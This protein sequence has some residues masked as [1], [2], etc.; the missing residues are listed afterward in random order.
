MDI[1][2]K[3]ILLLGGAGEVGMAIARTLL[4]HEEKPGKLVV[5]SLKKEEAEAA[6][7]ELQQEFPGVGVEFATEYGNIF[8]REEF[9]DRA[10]WELQADPACQEALMDD[11][12]NEL[13]PEILQNST[14]YQMIL[15][16]KPHLIV[17]TIN[18]ATALAY[19]DVYTTARE[20]RSLLKSGKDEE[21]LRAVVRRL[22]STLYIP[23]LVRHVQILHRAMEEVGV[24][25]YLK[26]GTTG[27][28][29]MGLNIPYT[30]GEERPSRVLLSKSAVAGAHSLLLFLADRTPRGPIVKEIKPAALIAWKAIGSGRIRKR[31][32]EFPLYQV[33]LDQAVP[34]KPGE[35]FD[36]R[37]F[38]ESP[39]SDAYLEAVFVDTGENGVFSLEEFKAITTLGQMEAV[40]PE[41][42]AAVVLDEIRGDN[43][44]FDVVSAL[45]ASVMGPTYRAGF[46]RPL[47]I[48]RLEREIQ[49]TGLNSVA[50]EILGPPRLSK[51]LFEA[52]LLKRCCGTLPAVL[53]LSEEDLSQRLVAYLREHPRFLQEI[54]AVG[55]AV[56]LPDQRLVFARR[57]DRLLDKH[58]ERN[59]WTVS[60]SQL[61]HW[62]HSEWIDLRPKNMK[63]WKKRLKKLLDELETGNTSTGS[64]YDRSLDQWP[65]NEK[66][67]PLVD[68]G[69]TVGYV[70]IQEDQGA[71]KKR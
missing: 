15:R 55:L 14:V 7:A 24:Q 22:L 42:I 32:R 52:E 50:F 25:L 5:A 9:K 13:T 57:H 34:L 19:Q 63:Q 30:H 61:E 49:R 37:R 44:S 4:E 31:G 35:T 46:L 17:D 43:T 65:T 62:A 27:T 45:D 48:R 59:R 26:V 18:T 56:L 1:Q 6:V 60:E 2:G 58:W 71:R 28:G 67:E 64:R 21:A 33:S 38:P 16:H 68:P 3:T 23:Q 47:V 53:A 11:I 51:L 10:W 8:V 36:L 29:G 54:L 41:E 70:F 66:G 39:A 12:L 69:E 20:A 40:T